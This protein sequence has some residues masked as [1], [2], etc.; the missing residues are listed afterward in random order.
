MEQIN[1]VLDLYSSAICLILIFYLFFGRSRRD[2]M[3]RYFLLMCIFN[4]GMAVG[5]IPNWVC[6][7][8]ARSWYPAALWAGTLIFW[9]CSSLMLLS[10]TAYLIE[11]LAPRVKVRPVFWRLAAILCCLHIAG[12]LLSIWNGMFFTILPENIYQRGYLFW[13]SQLIPFAIY[14]VDVAIFVSCR[15]HLSRRDFHIL[16]SY[17][18]LPL[19]AET[20]QMLYYGIA[21][22]NTGV[23]LG[24]LIIFINIQTEQELRLEHQE[25]ELAEARIDIMLSQIQP[26]FLFN[27]LTT[28]RSLC[29][30]N[31]QQAKDAIRD[32]ALFL[33]ANMDSLKSKTPIP[34]D[35]E[36]LHVKSYLALEQQRFQ[37]RL[38]VSYD[39]GVLD[40]SIP[41]LTVQPVVENA[42]RHGILKKAE[43]GMV[44]IRT[45]ETDTDY[46]ITVTDNGVG[47]PPNQGSND[48]RSHIGIEN[49]RVRLSA[50]CGGTLK[51]QSQAGTGTTVVIKIPK[52][53]APTALS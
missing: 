26:H 36:L 4:F 52:E 23:A 13:L 49:V 10:F 1:V 22:L 32:F 16:S 39:I 29:D 44:T 17:I 45:N 40:F 18:I 12:I 53:N 19:A 34:F 35:Q 30:H 48:N 7:G 43:G 38:A 8:L 31:P 47:F 9:L 51:I 28:I 21:L 20:I 2:K 25:K 37:S 6:N 27:S 14:A 33:R 15:K 3:Q 24:L 46:V 5:D 11:Y 41:P 50:L 42:V